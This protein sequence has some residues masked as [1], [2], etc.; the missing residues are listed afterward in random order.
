MICAV[1]VAGSFTKSD[2]QA[3][4]V[5]LKR[6]AELVKSVFGFLRAN[7]FRELRAK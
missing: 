2:S 1:V 5:D 3:K 6:N 7:W 4:L